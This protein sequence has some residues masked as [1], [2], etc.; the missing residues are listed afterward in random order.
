MKKSRTF[1]LVVASLFSALLLGSCGSK[2]TEDTTSNDGKVTIN[3]L[4][5]EDYMDE[6]LLDAFMEEYPECNV[7]FNKTDTNETLYNELRTGKADYN[8]VTVSEYMIQ[9]MAGEGLVQKIALPEDSDY[10]INV[11]PWLTNDEGTGVIDKIDVKDSKSGEKLGV[12]SEYTTGYMWGTLGTVVNPYYS[13]YQERNMSKDYIVDSLRGNDGWSTFWNKEFKGTHSIKESMRDT[14]ALGIFEVFK[15]EFLDPNISYEDKN[16][17]YFNDHSKE[18]IEKVK[19]SL[20]DLKSNIFGFEVDSGKNDIVTGKIGMNLAWSGDAAFSIL[21][22][23]FYPGP[24]EDYSEEKPDNKKTKLYYNIPESG[25][26]IWFDGFA[27]PSTTDPNSK[28]YEYT[29]K[30]IDFLSRPENA[31]A[32]MSYTGFTSFISGV[33][34]EGNLVADFVKETFDCAPEDRTTKHEPYD[35]SYFF[36]NGTT[37]PMVVYVDPDTFEGRMIVAQYPE[38]SDI[39]HLYIMEDYGKDNGKIV[40]MWEDIKVNPLPLWV[41]IFLVT[42]FV[43]LITYFG[44]Y[45]IIKARRIRK[46][47]ELR[48]QKD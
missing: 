40:Q 45:K 24:D 28:E 12:L 48:N 13:V 36:N 47:K 44:A 15:D 21:K 14:Y 33:G 7:V 9:R 26:N 20:I 35:I 8:L 11:S 34:I 46:R 10:H 5:Q 38:A 27:M 42:F 19:D 16:G 25:S 32:N 1:T 3:I 2:K 37:E 18:T 17:K 23:E 39:D 22:G 31:V 41:D 43:V 29:L 30:F 6:S 4:H